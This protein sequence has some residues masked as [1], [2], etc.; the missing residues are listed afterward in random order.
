MYVMAICTLNKI[1]HY[2][3]NNKV[4]AENMRLHNMLG[5]N[6][7]CIGD[8]DSARESL[9]KSQGIAKATGNTVYLGFVLHN[10]GCLCAKEKN[11]EQALIHFNE[12][13]NYIKEGTKYYFENLYFEIYCL[14]SIK[15]HLSEERLLYA[16]SMSESKDNEHYS[17]LFDALVCH[18]RFNRQ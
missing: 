1:C 16:K 8:F 11:F 13:F 6:C 10:L 12:A 5:V 18:S 14:I 15:S 4:S 7:T 17:A 3:E 9:E 2:Y